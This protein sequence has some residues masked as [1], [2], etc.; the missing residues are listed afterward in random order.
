MSE[1]LLQEIKTEL[2]EIRDMQE[3]QGTVFTSSYSNFAKNYIR[4]EHLERFTDKLDVFCESLKS[5]K[6]ETKKNT[7]F[8]NRMTGGMVLVGFIGVANIASFIFYIA[9]I[10]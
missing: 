10:L 3:T 2:G 5:N 7:E 8:R 1:K 6:E 4:S 9:K